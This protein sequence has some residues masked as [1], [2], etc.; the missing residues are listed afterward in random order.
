MEGLGD[1]RMV[2][3]PC[4][5]AG[6]ILQY[7][8]FAKKPMAFPCHRITERCSK[9]LAVAGIALELLSLWLLPLCV[10]YPMSSSCLVFLYYWKESKKARN[11]AV[12]RSR[13]LA[14]CGAVLSAWLLPFVA[15]PMNGYP[16][17]RLSALLEAVLGPS[18]CLYV[19]GLLVLGVLTHC[20]TAAQPGR[21]VIRSCAPAAFNFGVSAMLLKALAEL[22]GL[23]IGSP[24]RPVIWVSLV[25]V[26]LLLL[27]VRSAAAT[28]LRKA[29][30][31]HDHLSVLASY[32]L[33]SGVAAA[34]TGGVVYGEL[35]RL[36]FQRQVTYAAVASLHCWG[37]RALSLSSD[38]KGYTSV[39]KDHGDEEAA[40][41][42]EVLPQQGGSKRTAVPG[43]GKT[44]EMVGVSA[45]KR[46]SDDQSSPLFRFS[47][48]PPSQTRTV[49][50]DARIEDDLFANALAPQR[51]ATLEPTM[52]GVPGAAATQDLGGIA[53][54]LG[55]LALPEPE[56]DADFEEIMRRFDED[57]RPHEDITAQ[58]RPSGDLSKP[59]EGASPP[60][61]L[62]GLDAQT[63]F[64]VSYGDGDGDEDEL[65]RSIQDIDLP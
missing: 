23:L 9:H 32:G 7:A 3:I 12:A 34:T 27:A 60:S 1:V 4:V 53:Q 30:E 59:V 52:L 56:F 58:R 14:T 22:A 44:V 2:A 47:E 57:D 21:E 50:E 54:D 28:P 42:A 36:G 38:P 31:V 37:M 6:S 15:V 39:P 24:E 63:L 5:L 43:S 64:D 55:G 49:D 16:R 11:V 51:L 62:T 65:L 29:I 18:T 41:H 26:T 8:H 17:V 25:V 20:W 46:S 35:S 13:E 40:V 45:S 48:A 19:A 61:V 10:L 33:L